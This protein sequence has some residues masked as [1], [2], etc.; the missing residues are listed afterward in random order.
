MDDIGPAARQYA[1]MGEMPNYLS[2]LRKMAERGYPS[3]R[4]LFFCR[5][6]LHLLSLGRS[7]EAADLW[8]QL[9]DDVPRGSSLVQFTGLL[10]VMVKHRPVPPTEE[11][12]QA[13]TMAKSKFANSLARDPELNQM[14]VRAGERY[15]G[16]VPA[17]P[18]GGLLGSIMSMLG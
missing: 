9:A 7:Q 11:S 13:F 16:I 17:A 1:F 3:E 6:V 10:M 5:A 15:F 4:D 8:S 14:V 12:A 2:L 18:A